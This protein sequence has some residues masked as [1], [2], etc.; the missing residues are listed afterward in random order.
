MAKHKAPEAVMTDHVDQ[1]KTTEAVKK[2]KLNLPDFSWGTDNG[3]LIWALL[4]KM[5]KPENKK[6]FFGKK[7]KHE[8]TQNISADTKTTTVFKCIGSKSPT[9]LM[10]S[11]FSRQGVGGGIGVV[12][13]EG[14]DRKEYLAF[15]V[16]PT[17]PD[18]MTTTEAFNIWHESLAESGLLP[19]LIPIQ[20]L[21]DPNQPL[22][23]D[24]TGIQSGPSGQPEED[25]K[26]QEVKLT[27]VPTAP[28]L[29]PCVLAK[30]NIVP[31]PAMES[32]GSKALNH[33]V[34]IK[35]MKASI[36][37]L[38]AKK[39]LLDMLLSL[40]EKNLKAINARVNA[41]SE[42]A[43]SKLLLKQKQHLLKELKLNIWI[44][45]EY[46]KKVRKLEKHHKAPPVA[47]PVS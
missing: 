21:Y 37:K 15:Y 30:E 25:D 4:D 12:T 28:T 24:D 42:H 16:P 22:W 2:K 27:K 39:T 36:K 34:S 10:P 40:Q 29:R 11:T 31:A 46:H 32:C 26:I 1:A 41:E 6:V 43:T 38:P 44:L 47:S 33:K 19:K 35:H 45:E 14:E 23:S 3:K 9:A 18:C 17:G 7:D 20:P 13:M 5:E 8:V